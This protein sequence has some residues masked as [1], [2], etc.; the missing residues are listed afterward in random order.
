MTVVAG[1]KGEGG[2]F[3]PLVVVIRNAM[4]TKEFNQLRGKAISLHS[5]GEYW[6]EVGGASCETAAAAGRRGHTCR[7]ACVGGGGA[8]GMLQHLVCIYILPHGLSLHCQSANASTRSPLLPLLAPPCL[9]S[10]RSF[11]SSWAPT[12]SRCR[13]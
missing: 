13:G 12:T 7:R 11:A 4:G 2:P 3:A 5:Q 6:A 8:C 9:Q 10:S 1:N